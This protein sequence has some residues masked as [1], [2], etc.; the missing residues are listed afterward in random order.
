M[1][2]KL[3]IVDFIYFLITI[4]IF[5]FGLGA[6]ISLPI[7]NEYKIIIFVFFFFLVLIYLELWRSNKTSRLSHKFLYLI[8]TQLNLMGTKKVIKR[9][10]VDEEFNKLENEIK[11]KN[12]FEQ[13]LG[14][15]FWDLFTIIL[16]LVLIIIVAAFAADY[17]Q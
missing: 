16:F 13:S 8:F 10:T 11:D 5:G 2:E 9:S 1:S 12:E 15:G 7:I 6:L 4:L 14:A 3:K 17:L